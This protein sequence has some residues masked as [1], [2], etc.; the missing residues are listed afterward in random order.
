MNV[1][2]PFPSAP[3]PLP[4]TPPPPP[5]ARPF[6]EVPALW[7]KLFQGRMDL[8]FF[9]QELP[10]A[11]GINALYGVLVTAAVSAVVTFVLSLL[12]GLVAGLTSGGISGSATAGLASTLGTIAV[13]GCCA[14]LFVVPASFYVNAGVLWLIAKLF[15]GKGAFGAQAYL[16]SLF[17]V[18]LTILSVL[19][20]IVEVIPVVGRYL[21]GLVVLVVAIFNLV[22]TV[23]A[24]QAAHALTG[25]KAAAVV[26]LPVAV[27]F[28]LG[29]CGVLV[30]LLSGPAIGNVFSSINNSLLAP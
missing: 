23:R 2:E 24:L 17:V 7:W 14:Q 29:C 3:A 21:F 30:L 8:A 4:T 15:G 25:G 13:A 22:L 27:G 5:P 9:Q 16:M 12:S 18:P 10:A 6:S 20:S 1:P 28:V 11:R 19:L 26:L